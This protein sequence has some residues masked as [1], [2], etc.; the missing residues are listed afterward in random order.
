MIAGLSCAGVV[1]IIAVS[2]ATEPEAQPTP[3][4]VYS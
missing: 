4:R 3:P 2:A 1:A